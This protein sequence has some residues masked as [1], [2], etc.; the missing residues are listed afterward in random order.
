[1]SLGIFAFR[2]L[3]KDRFLSLY[4]DGEARLQRRDEAYSQ[5][6]NQCTFRP[7][8]SASND[9]GMGENADR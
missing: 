9:N 5:L 6:P 3:N 7:D 8:I 4:K 1:M 2:G